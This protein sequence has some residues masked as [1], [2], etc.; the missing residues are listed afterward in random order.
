[1]AI[2]IIKDKCIGCGICFKACPA[3]AFEFEPYDGNKLGK[4]AKINAKCTFCNQCLTAC[5]FGA[6]EEEKIEAATDLDDYKHVWVYAE[7]RD[8]K[9]MNVA[10]ELIGEG[11]RLAKEI[12]DDT[13]VCAVLIGDGIDHLADECFAYGAREGLHDPGSSPEELHN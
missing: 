2:K 1:M 11:Y 7:Q 13:Q 4:V 3:D 12:S 6:I 5:K 9:L 10:L 8:G